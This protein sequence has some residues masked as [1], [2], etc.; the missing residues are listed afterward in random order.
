MQRVK[1]PTACS[2]LLLAATAFGCSSQ[3][4]LGHDLK[5]RVTTPSNTPGT[6]NPGDMPDAADAPDARDDPDASSTP[7]KGVIPTA[8][9][10]PTSS[11][12]V[13]I[14]CFA[15]SVL[16]LATS[17]G[18]AKGLVMDADNVFWAA[19]VG[20]ALMVTPRDGS[21]T[22]AI[23]TPMAGPFRIDEDETN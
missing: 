10:G 17:E 22:T 6:T 20:Q 19:T 4:D 2:C 12:C 16:D 1:R 15:G 8:P 23:S 9:N 13:G 3:L 5:V 14:P 11:T 21:V 18:S 7:S